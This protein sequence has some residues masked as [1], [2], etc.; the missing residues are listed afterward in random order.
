M[1]SFEEAGLSFL[2]ASSVDNYN[3]NPA[4]W[5]TR[6]L[7]GVKNPVA[8]AVIRTAAIKA[9][10]AHVMRGATLEEGE[11]LARRHFDQCRL[12]VADELAGGIPAEQDAILPMFHEVSKALQGVALGKF[13]GPGVF[14]TVWLDGISVPF[15]SKPDLVFEE[16]VVDVY[17]SNRLLSTPSDKHLANAALH[18]LHCGRD[19]II[20]Y[21]T[22]KKRGVHY[23]TAVDCLKAVGRL[24][25][26]AARIEELVTR[27]ER[28]EDALGFLPLRPDHFLWSE[29]SLAAAAVAL[30]NPARR[31]RLAGAYTH[32]GDDTTIQLP[33]A[34]YGLDDASEP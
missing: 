14:N 25:R 13:I 12:D 31:R 10:V 23:L 9:A 30:D 18:K 21:A 33:G 1:A 5:V 8:P 4:Y 2:S 26:E 32:G 22:M 24:R 11:D 20:V 17:P 6:Y 3:A 7:L 28:P 27:I 15:M 29:T 19:P 16:C 34:S